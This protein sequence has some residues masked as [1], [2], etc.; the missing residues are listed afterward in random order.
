MLPSPIIEGTLP[1]FYYSD[2]KGCAELVI[3]FSMSRAVGESEVY[4]FKLKIKDIQNYEYL[5][6]LTESEIQ[7]N[8]GIVKFRIDK[9][10]LDS[11]FL[12]GQF[13]KA[14]L[15]YIDK[16]G[17]PGY[18]STVGIIKYTTKP[19]VEILGLKRTTNNAH[20]YT[21]TGSYSQKGQDVSEKEYAYKFVVTDELGSIVEDTGFIIHNNSNDTNNYES[22][23]IFKFSKDLQE[24][25]KYSIAY[26]VKTNNNL[27]V[28]S[29]SYRIMNKKAIVSTL[30]AKLKAELNFENGYVHLWLEGDRDEN[31]YEKL[32]TGSFVLARASEESNYT[33]WEDLFE[34]SLASQ[35]P[36]LKSWKDFTIQQGINYKYSVQQRN[37]K[38]LQSARI[39]SNI[40]YADFEYNFLYD[41]E[42]QLKIKFNPK[43]SSF[44][45]DILESKVDTLGSKYP[46][47][48]RNGQVEYKEFPIQGLISYLSD[49]ENLFSIQTKDLFYSKERSRKT[50]YTEIFNPLRDIIS[51]TDPN[52]LKERQETYL[53]KNNYMY[54]YVYDSKTKT[55]QRWTSYAKNLP[56]RKAPNGE[57]S[58]FFK[59]D[60]QD[61]DSVYR[62]YTEAV[63]SPSG[64]RV[65]SP[66]IPPYSMFDASWIEADVL[67]YDNRKWASTNL[68]SYNVFTEREFKIEVL[69]WL[70]NGK[71][72]LFKSP[73]EGNYIVR[74]MN[75]ALQP[76]DQLGRML[77]NFTSTA[78]EIADMNY[79]SLVE[80]GIIGDRYDTK[81]YVRIVTIPL[82]TKDQNYVNLSPIKYIYD[83]NANMY[84]A[85]GHLLKKGVEIQNAVLTDMIP[86]SKVYIND[87]PIIIGSTG[88]YEV[89]FEVS[90]VSLPEGMKSN[91]LLTIQYMSAINDSFNTIERVETE[92][93]IGKQIIGQC[94]N[95][96]D[97]INNITSQAV[98]F[99]DIRLNKRP[100]IDLYTLD[101][102]R[103]IEIVDAN[104][105]NPTNVT[106][107]YIQKPIY[108]E[109]EL[110]EETYQ[111]GIYYYKAG[112]DYY[113]SWFA[114]DAEETYYTI[115]DYF[116]NKATQYISTEKY[117]KKEAG[118]EV[119]EHVDD[120]ENKIP[121][122]LVYQLQNKGE[123][124]LLVENRLEANPL[125]LYRFSVDYD[126]IVSTYLY[127]EQFF[128]ETDKK[129]R[130]NNMDRSLFNRLTTNP[131]LHNNRD[132]KW[133]VQNKML[134][135]FDK[136]QKEF[137]EVEILTP[138]N[139]ERY[140]IK[141]PIYYVYD[142]INPDTFYIDK[143][144][145]E[146]FKLLYSAD[147]KQQAPN[148]FR[149]YN[150]ITYVA[151]LNNEP[152]NM[153]DR[154]IMKTGPMG[155]IESLSIP[156]GLY[157]ELFY[158]NQAI[159][160]DISQNANLVYLRNQL[161]EMETKLSREYMEKACSTEEGEQAYAEQLNQIYISYLPLKYSYIKELEAYLKQLE[162]E[163]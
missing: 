156:A 115:T 32:V 71:P 108:E 22:S 135:Y 142:P 40:I 109:I 75:V 110:T 157:C 126:D 101:Y 56:P 94:N 120:P 97:T 53:Y 52:K 64:V 16:N 149:K 153:E 80:Y 45:K 127:E 5:L 100:M 31:N 73:T 132:F 78:Y 113:I 3:P 154:E 103:F 77:H 68:D 107:Y 134:F 117:Y 144:T 12:I 6:T 114:F 57:P 10:T 50:S 140:F 59:I 84:F 25:E 26:I 42:R 151:F 150:K 8:N 58:K 62:Y 85:T 98:T 119:F 38:G 29:P 51:V 96:L 130:L 34:F 158:Q 44:K 102:E 18:Y 111:S 159:Y 70:T 105:V 125:A 65:E 79:K 67:D 11:K 7:F 60:F 66:P 139:G 122:V 131:N 13:Y 28:S 30:T 155:M 76:Q 147:F 69:N 82:S 63:Y 35:R 15:A 161:D 87:E 104:V 141:K 81:Q 163:V 118:F 145:Y 41:G 116:F 162:E 4:G 33:D 20:I 146:R 148:I 133:F 160:H 46:F 48:F 91:G 24:N 83:E 47:I 86:G 106:E 72:K 21:Y 49:E 27:E 39:L 136:T 137:K 95:V 112:N 90:Q 138:K 14:Q 121:P 43:M 152:L 1:A 61:W 143:E 2:E 129:D 23:D 99:Y 17:T 93:I 36:S 92:E 37:K 128:D 88:T 19:V 54:Y 9:S 124:P 55:Y 89:P 123:M 74:L